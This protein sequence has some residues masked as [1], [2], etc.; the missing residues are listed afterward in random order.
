MKNFLKA[1]K[2][3]IIHCVLIVVSLLLIFEFINWR[4]QEGLLKGFITED[5]SQDALYD[6]RYTFKE[7]TGPLVQ[8]FEVTTDIF[9]GVGLNFERAQMT[10]EGTI[11]IKITAADG[12]VFFD[13]K[14]PI[15]SMSNK[16]K[17]WVVFNRMLT[18][19]KGKTFEIQMQIQDV[20]RYDSLSIYLN[21]DPSTA[22]GTL[23]DATGKLDGNIK[24]GQIYGQNL[25]MKKLVY[26]FE[27]AIALMIL[28]LYF[29]VFVKKVKIE[30]I[31][32]IL[33]IFLGFSYA[34]L[35]SPGS[36]PDEIAHF[37]TAYAYSNLLMG[38][39]DGMD[40]PI[41]MDKT[42]FAVYRELSLLP[43]SPDTYNNLYENIFQKGD[44]S[45]VVD[46]NQRAI[47]SPGYWYVGSA[48]GITASRVAGFS[49][50]TTFYLGRFFNVI[51]FAFLAFLAMKKLPFYKM[52]IFAICLFPTVLQSVGSFSYDAP[53]LA[54]AMI[55]FA[56]IAAVILGDQ[57]KASYKDLIIIAISAILLS[58]CKGGAYIPICGLV[59]L[60]SQKYFNDRK[61]RWIFVGGVA[62]CAVIVFCL[63]SLSSISSSV[64]GVNQYNQPLYK[65]EW[66]LREPIEFIR[67]ILN[68]IF[69]KSGDIFNSFV[70]S[71][72]ESFSV[73][74][75]QLVVLG[76][77]V[78]FLM[79]CIYVIEGPKT[80]IFRREQKIMICV[81]SL[82]VVAMVVAAML[83]SWTPMGAEYIVGIQGRYFLPFMLPLAFCLK[84]QT[85]T[86]KRSL[87]PQL[88]FTLGWLQLITF[89]AIMNT[90]LVV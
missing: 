82:M 28:G 77:F 11:A 47:K 62:I 31:F 35:L 50:I 53:I 17:Y 45:T 13:E 20:D 21:E 70:G 7:E 72:L 15:S 23:S 89:I 44:R 66:V 12:E 30:R 64:G 63:T 73:Q 3:I 34:T 6:G 61:Q 54:I 60:L 76:F 80:A 32:L 39:G 74:I 1:N 4:C 57:E 71:S 86:L 49:G 25:R 48:L 81:I 46:T 14:I 5:I 78:V 59:L 36:P 85:L 38:V 55:L 68:T 40:A 9:W 87:D 24:I 52:I 2:K 10:P 56:N 29:A 22:S 51:L 43:A 67:V 27:A 16:K 88:I 33:T 19:A 41:K 65:I 37:R 18:D 69:V 83:F 84:N 8:S 42:D 26:C 79:S 90:V 58:G 75:P